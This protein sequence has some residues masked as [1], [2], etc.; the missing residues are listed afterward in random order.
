MQLINIE[1]ENSLLGC[2]FKDVSLIKETQVQTKHFHDA[3]NKIIFD[4]LKELD[5]KGEPIDVVT[6]ITAIRPEN[7]SKIG[8]PQ[9]LTMLESVSVNIENYKTYENYIIEAWKVREAKRLQETE[10]SSLED[11]RSLQEK[12]AE[13][14]E[15][16]TEE[17]YDH[18]ETLIQLHRDIEK[19]KEGLSGYDTGFKDL[20]N[21]LDGF[22]E[23]DLII[24]AARPSV[25][26]TAK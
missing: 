21:Y 13:L 10:I 19:Q 7:L 2:M 26:K 23:G 12:L 5:S 22:Q 24:T 11:I 3:A 1:A 20:N 14:D 4:T 25:G 16:T 18:K 9:K 15:N 17:E 6:I 8:G